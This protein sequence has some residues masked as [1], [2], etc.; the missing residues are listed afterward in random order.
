MPNALHD[1]LTA[2][3]QSGEFDLLQDAAGALAER[4]LRVGAHPDDLLLVDDRTA[5]RRIASAA[6]CDNLTAAVLL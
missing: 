4:S 2:I 3:Q 1:A 5:E 6:A